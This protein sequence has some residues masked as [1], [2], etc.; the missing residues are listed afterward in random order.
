M[1][2]WLQRIGV[3]LLIV[4]LVVGGLGWATVEALDLEEH[5]RAAAAETQRAEQLRM[6]MWRIDGWIAPLLARE[7][8]RPFAHYSAIHAPIPAMTRHTDPLPAGVVRLPSPLLDAQLPDW[9]LLHFQYTPTNP[10]ATAW[11]SPQVLPAA[12]IER[13]RG[14]PFDLPLRNVT[15]DRAQL[16]A[17]ISQ[18]FSASLL[19]AMVKDYS[20]LSSPS[21]VALDFNQNPPWNFYN[22]SQQQQQLLPNSGA[23]APQQAGYEDFGTRLSTLQKSRAPTRGSVERNSNLDLDQLTSSKDSGVPQSVELG[24]MVPLWFPYPTQPDY[25][26]LVRYTRLGSKDVIQGVVFDWPRL[27]SDLKEMISDLFPE[28][29]FHPATEVL[30]GRPERVM[31]MLP[32]VLHPGPAAPAPAPSWTPLR[33]GLTLAWIAA[34][35]ALIA[36]AFGGWSL[37]DLSERR[38]RFVSAVTH[39]LRTPLTTLRLYLDMLNSGMVSDE[40]QKEEYLQTLAGESERL[41]RLISNVLDFSRLEKQRAKAAPTEIG[42]DEL[43]ES[44]RST[45]TER[46]ARAGKELIVENGVDSA[47]RVTTDTALVQQIVG[48]FID[49]ACKYSRSALDR[50]IWLRT[51]VNGAGSIA[52]EVEDCGPGVQPGER[53]SIFR[54]FRRGKSADVTAGGVGL[55][56]ALAER[57][58][59]MLGGR[60]AY[61]KGPQANG[62]CFRLELPLAKA[63]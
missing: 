1:S 12:W 37:I 47:V 10:A 59:G 7:D 56:L 28:A 6:A 23:Q 35:L 45:W 25:L 49:N 60:L 54:A 38:I 29:S 18:D 61:H 4:L 50:R 42:V 13:L 16:L 36:V 51:H 33:I 21:D 17:K 27:Q 32:V 46:C 26:L 53:R 34:A 11:Q 57:W 41:H 5:K 20:V 63:S 22:N 58:A 62:A 15:P 30:P 44:V 19:A 3:F 48:N 55:G 40:K 31:T 9:M 39:E 52:I 14:R 24:G 8:S 2:P 43:I